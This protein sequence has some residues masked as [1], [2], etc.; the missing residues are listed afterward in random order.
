M[1]LRFFLR[2]FLLFG[3]GLGGFLRLFPFFRRFF[4][5]LFRLRFLLHLPGAPHQLVK[6][7]AEEAV[8]AGVFGEGLAV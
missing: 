1:N 7:E 5:L 2:L 3:L 6:G 8:L 4:L